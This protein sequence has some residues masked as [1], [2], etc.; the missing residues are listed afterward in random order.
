M[1]LQQKI[2]YT[3]LLL[4]WGTLVSCTPLVRGD[5]SNSATPQPP[6]VREIVRSNEIRTL[7]GQLD[8]IPMLN[9]NSPEW[10]KTEGILLSTFPPENKQVPTAHL[11]F[12]FK[13][14]FILFASHFTHTP[15]NL[16]TLYLGILV[17]NPG[18]QSV[19]LS[20]PA[21]ASYLL[22]P[23]APFKQQ[24]P[25]SE[26]PNGEIYSGPGIR[27]ADSLLRG[28][29]QADFPARLT[30]P[31]G[32]SRMLMNHP[33]PVKGLEKPINGRGN[34]FR[35]N[36]SDAV[37]VA[38]LAL[39]AKQ[40]PDGTERAPTLA[41]WQQLLNTGGLAGPRDKIP[42]PPEQTDGQLI[43]GRVAGVQQGSTWQAT[44]TDTGS[45]QLNIPTADQ[46][47]SYVIS[48]LRGGRLGTEQSQAA[49]M[50]VRYPDTAY[51]A[52]ANYGVH[53]DLTL[54]LSNP[55]DQPTTVALTLETP[56]KEDRLSR[57]GLIFR[58]PPWDFPFFRGTVRLRYVDDSQKDLTRYV[59]LW[60]RQGQT[61]DPLVKLTLQPQETRSIR[62]DFLYP[63]D[64][65]PPQVL[66]VSGE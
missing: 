11:N 4:N 46:P 49:P 17:Q 55:T 13:G 51:E 42:T 65:V 33:I 3:L 66:T 61:I 26:N 23:D 62:I 48:T 50:L 2:A 53:Y 36:S 52:H 29:R 10:V 39:Y 38:S 31:P 56:R 8:N 27:A 57:N 28:I 43:Y 35:L 59:H 14:E 44:L 37:Y 30:I 20:I 18:K 41:E 21:A 7:P 16:Q 60:H 1:K 9:S 12:P 5:T 15:P 58:Q 24:P 34:F 32:E 19:T 54:P 63:P 45:T 6:A 25:M 47:I 40:N 64:S 22:E